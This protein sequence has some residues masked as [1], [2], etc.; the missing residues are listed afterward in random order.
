[1]VLSIDRL[2]S[3]NKKEGLIDFSKKEEKKEIKKEEKVKEELPDLYPVGVVHG[4]YI[5][6]QNETGMYLIDQHAA[7]ERINYEKF[8]VEM[9]KPTKD[10]IYPI[11]PYVIELSASEAI[12]MK[13]RMDTLREIG[14][15]VEEI[16]INSIVIKAHP[17][18]LIK[19]YEE[20]Q[21]RKI[22]EIVLETKDFSIEKFRESAATMMSCKKAIK[23]N[24]Y[25]S[26]EEVEK[27]LDD[28]R[29]CD[30]PFNCPHGRPTIIYYSNYDLEKLFKRTGFEI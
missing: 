17:T 12:I 18:W 8:K 25:I 14:F 16:G 26:P 21:I 22:V 23:A 20:E 13:E 7:K 24:E 11:F 6:C 28:L 29:H 9:G 30:N 3:E 27:L 10:K 2:W 15:E 1:M 19:D 5:I 4:T